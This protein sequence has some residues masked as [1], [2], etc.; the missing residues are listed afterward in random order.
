M[1]TEIMSNP[2]I[3]YGHVFEEGVDYGMEIQSES[4]TE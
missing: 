2:F 3:G 4:D 1:K